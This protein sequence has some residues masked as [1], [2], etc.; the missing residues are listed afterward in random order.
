M[1]NVDAAVDFSRLDSRALDVSADHRSVT[2]TLPRARLLEPRV[3]P[4]R[5]HV[6][7]RQ[8]GLVD[9]VESLFEDNPT[10]E[11][12]LYVL[13]QRKLAAAARAPG[14]GLVTS[15]ERNT[16]TMLERMLR[17][18]GFERGRGPLRIAPLARR[19]SR[20]GVA[21]RPLKLGRAAIPTRSSECRGD[22]SIGVACPG[23]CRSSLRRSLPGG[24]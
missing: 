2:V 17:G 22:R 15:A 12:E 24:F 20:Q 7:D 23:A 11:R 18:L 5:S 21:T 13:A 10:S 16:G 4:A 3:D 14:A 1:G 6:V 8:R 19:A 9:R